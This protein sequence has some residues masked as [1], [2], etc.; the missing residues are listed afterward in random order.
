MRQSIC[1]ESDYQSGEAQKSLD[2]VLE[3]SA[4]LLRIM[5]QRAVR[6]GH[7]GGRNPQSYARTWKDNGTRQ[8]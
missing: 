6:R 3:A 7:S 1:G 8:Y 2:T 5:R 4:E